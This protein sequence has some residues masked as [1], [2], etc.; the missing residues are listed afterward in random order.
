MN[1]RRNRYLRPR[2]SVRRSRSSIGSTARPLVQPLE[3]RKLLSA[4]P[5]LIGSALDLDPSD[6]LRGEDGDGTLLYP[7]HD[8]LIDERFPAGQERVPD[9]EEPAPDEEEIDPFELGD[10]DCIL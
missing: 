7:Y 4:T 6:Y 10:G 8:E 1:H 2:P 5:A 9:E 3:P